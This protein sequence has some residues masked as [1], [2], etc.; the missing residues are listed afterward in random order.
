[1]ESF[2]V[3]KYKQLLEKAQKERKAVVFV[4]NPTGGFK[5]AFFGI[6]KNRGFIQSLFA[7]DNAQN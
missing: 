3:G 2:D 6:E 4:P 1:M 7:K 5:V